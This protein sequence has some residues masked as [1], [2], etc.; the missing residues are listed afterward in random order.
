MGHRM[1]ERRSS[2]RHRSD[3]EAWITHETLPA[4]VACTIW[5]LSET[6]VRLVI[7]KPADVPIQFELQVPSE[8]AAAKVRLVWTTGVQYGAQ[9][10]D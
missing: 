9:F 5:D 8:G 3:L 10:T 2:E 1:P 6:G 4:P 7:T